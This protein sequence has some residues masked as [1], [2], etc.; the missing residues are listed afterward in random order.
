T[1]GWPAASPSRWCRRPPPPTRR[2]TPTEL[3]GRAGGVSPRRRTPP[4]THVP[5]SPT[6]TCEHCELPGPVT[7]TPMRQSSSTIGM[8]VLGALL[9][10]PGT[11][12]AGRLAAAGPELTR[13]HILMVFDTN[14]KELARSLKLDEE[15]LLQLWGE[16]IPSD[17]YRLTVLRGNQTNKAE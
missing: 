5:G 4:G 13:L 6:S 7:E 10:A 17:R 2:L 9:T 8:L 11:P 15:R 12:L 16:T 1:R 3:V 14:A